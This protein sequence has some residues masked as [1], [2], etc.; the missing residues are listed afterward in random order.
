[1]EN[2]SRNLSLLFLYLCLSTL[3]FNTDVLA[4]DLDNVT[5][6]G[7]ITD[8][9][10]APVVGAT[11]AVIL[12]E[13]TTERTAITDDEGRYRII[14]LQPGTYNVRA[15]ASGFGAKE[16]QGFITIAG[17][18]LQLNFSLAP[19]GVQAEQTVIVTED[20]A[21]AVD[22]TRTV[23]GGTVTQREIEE[24]PNNTR[25]PLDLVFTLGGVA[26][27]PLS[28]RDAAED[29]ARPGGD[30]FNDPRPSPLESGIFSLSGG[31]AYS[32]NITIDGLDNNDD[33]L[34]QD[35]FQPSIDS[36]A[37]VQV[38]TNQFSAEYGRASG[39]RVNI[40][41]RG[42]T[43]KF[44]G[45][46]FLYFRDD[47]L[48]AN[49]FNN[50]RRGLAR[51][52]FTEY[53]PGFTI[54]GPIPFG[55]FKDKTFFFTSY[56]Y[57]NLQDTTLI[58]TVV[59]I[60]QNPNFALPTPTA[61]NPRFEQPPSGFP[62]LSVAQFAPF[63]NTIPTPSNKHTFSTRIDYNFTDKHNAT[64]SFE[65]G[66][67]RS[68]RQF[69][70][71]TSRLEEAILGPA[72][73]TD[74]Y[75]FTDNYVFNSKVVNQFRFQFSRFE[76]NFTS[77]NPTDPV[78]LITL[79]DGVGV[80]SRSGTLIAGNS[81]AAQNFNFPGT[82]NETRYQFQETLNVIAGDHSLKFGADAQIIKSDFLDLQDA[83]GT[84]NFLTVRNFLDNNV[85]RYRRNFGR[86][87]GQEN[88]YYSFFAQDEWRLRSDLTLSLGVRYEK[89]TIIG[90]DNNFGPRAAIAFAPFKDG[91]GVIRVGGGIFYNRVLLRTFDDANLSESRRS[92][93]S[94]RL[95]GPATTQNFVCFDQANAGYNL[96]RC[97][98]LRRI[99]FP[100]AAT[101][102][103]L[104]NIENQLRQSGVLTAAQTGFSTPE[105]NLRRIDP[106]LKVPESYQF[107]VGFEREIGSGLVFE[108]NYTFNRTIRLF[109][110]FN[111]NPYNLPAGFA[112][113][114]DYLVNGYQNPT[115]RF[116]NGD[117]TDINGVSTANGITTVN[118]ASRN[119]SAGATTPIG[120]ARAIL[121]ALGRRLGSNFP[122]QIDQVASIG[123][124][125]YNGLIVE[126]RRR[127][128]KFG[129]G[130]GGSFRA[131]YT[132]S[133]TEDDGNNNTTNPQNIFDFSSEFT[134]SL[135]D[136]RHRFAFS[137]TFDLPDWAGGLRLSPLVRLSSGAPF[138]ISN[139][140]GLAND[141]NLDEVS[142]DRPNFS[143]NLDDLI[144]RERGSAFLQSVFN[145][146]N[147]API[148]SSGNIPRNA[149]KGPG[150]FL[151]DLNITRDF[152]FSE[153][154][155][156]RP[157]VEIGNVF[158]TTI[159][160]FG[161]EFIN[162]NPTNA[163]QRIL[164]E[165]EFL[166]PSR[167]L[168]ARTIRL[169]MRFDF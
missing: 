68:T 73:T 125:E 58:D 62:N 142:T 50:N 166:V 39:G 119:P 38:I 95:P 54:G 70:T 41:T 98:L 153:R 165:Q 140:T 134:S 83:T 57:N 120:R 81:T 131:V 31:A 1:M 29:R 44:R 169:G 34:A 67:S 72:R 3:I 109:R 63:V 99:D 26:E 97:Q 69:R 20:D 157:S 80:D 78:V 144:F 122:E 25:N 113:Y 66:N 9:N 103:E 112:D 158:N 136:R 86:Q 150:Q 100:N 145:Q 79:N 4:Q 90:D 47:Y 133:K 42:G 108:S 8:S 64:F 60:Q 168:R 127:F 7:R 13:T 53:N 82:R 88:T 160:T 147:F 141:R 74:A 32:N 162:F 102:E 91:K 51:L 36:I 75:K 161:S 155:S 117:A 167:T 30:S 2:L 143:G 124:A 6:S 27:E 28:V 56:E 24:L 129:Y 16:N 151:F 126:L 94:N 89:E 35:R 149:G 84:F 116:V 114:N 132:L 156:L 146:F 138:N 101:F 61:A 77:T 159:F 59:P 65:Y 71:A 10:N 40:R 139:G 111:A 118:L 19:A 45:R 22:T 17:Q 128:R 21:P 121:N 110:E 123:R 87:T 76:P 164:F 37:E 93:D 14:E 33:R 96:A 92:Y 106:T 105:N 23:V 55:Y 46:A 107:N 137:G 52:P 135:Q 148:G 85:G 15:S 130:F 104:T 43:K 5:I 154:F 49:S 152:K 12:V 11:V 115:L 18:N 48:N 163:E